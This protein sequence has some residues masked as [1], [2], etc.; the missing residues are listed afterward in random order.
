MK[1]IVMVWIMLLMCVSFVSAQTEEEKESLGSFT[2]RLESKLEENKAE[3]GQNDTEAE[4]DEEEVEVDLSEGKKPKKEK[5]TTEVEVEIETET[6]TKT[7]KETTVT[8]QTTP[9]PIQE[10]KLLVS[11]WF[12]TAA[13]QSTYI[14]NAY[15][16]LTGGEVEWLFL[17]TV[18]FGGA[19]YMLS[20]IEGSSIPTDRM[21]IF[22]Y[23]GLNAGLIINRK[24]SV[25]YSIYSLFGYGLME[26][27]YT[28]TGA[29]VPN[30][31]K[32]LIVIEPGVDVDFNMGKNVKLS[33]GARFRYVYN[34]SQDY[35]GVFED[36]GLSG[37]SL[38]FAVKFGR[39]R[40]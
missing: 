40:R 6:T 1:K 29:L 14:G 39:F 31:Q 19:F 34:I 16:N 22:G 23:G 33:V 13:N 4:K 36:T 7:T 11:S 30:S 5:E 8:P 38:V 21:P 17:E 25:S 27:V 10:P 35:S 3:K 28:S 2:D 9:P 12:G 20:A 18:Y 24:K 32:D 26:E 15:I 37:V